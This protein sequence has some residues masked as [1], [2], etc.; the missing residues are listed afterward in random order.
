MKKLIMTILGSVGLLHA[1]LSIKQIE[2]MVEQ[3]H[4]KRKGREGIDIETLKHT[5]EPF[6]FG[7][8][9]QDSM[10]INSSKKEES[11]IVLHAIMS[12]RA[13]IND[14]WKKV[15]DKVLEYTVKYI[16]KHGAVLRNGD[17]IKKLF[18]RKPK[19][20]FITIKERK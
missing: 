20:N 14:G 19:D 8:N 2:Q 1:E 4:L 11:R 13:Y 18:F 16:G 9:R 7:K 15:D 12:N 17:S 10:T 5:K 6:M 3:I